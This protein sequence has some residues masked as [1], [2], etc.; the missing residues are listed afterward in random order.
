MYYVH[1]DKVL[2]LLIIWLMLRLGFL[3]IL[4][5]FGKGSKLWASAQ[6]CA[7]IVQWYLFC[8][9]IYSM[10]LDRIGTIAY[11]INLNG[12]FRK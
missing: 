9:R 1:R 2:K 11:T 4:A 6:H 3:L 12:F 8:L 10:N 5:S 7:T